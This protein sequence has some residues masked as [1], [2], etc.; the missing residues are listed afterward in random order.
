MKECPLIFQDRGVFSSAA[1]PKPCS[2]VT[3][4]QKAMPDIPENSFTQP[5]TSNVSILFMIYHTLMALGVH[6]VFSKTLWHLGPESKSRSE[7]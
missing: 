7:F 3:R 4:P 5:P 2:C 1:Q 6:W